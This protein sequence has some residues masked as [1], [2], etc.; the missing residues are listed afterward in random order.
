MAAR[1]LSTPGQIEYE[2][3]LAPAARWEQN[4][5]WIQIYVRSRTPNVLVL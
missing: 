4:G 1:S 5:Q 2:L 3:G